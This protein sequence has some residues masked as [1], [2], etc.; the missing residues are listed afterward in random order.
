MVLVFGGFNFSDCYYLLLLASI[1][2]VVVCRQPPSSSSSSSLVLFLPLA[3]FLV[4]HL[5]RHHPTRERGHYSIRSNPTNPDSHASNDEESKRKNPKSKMNS[6]A[7]K[8][9]LK[10]ETTRD[11]P[12]G[13]PLAGVCCGSL[14]G[15]GIAVTQKSM[16]HAGKWDSCTSCCIGGC[17]FCFAL[18]GLRL[19]QGVACV[20]VSS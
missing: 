4:S 2:R 13:P 6:A 11:E 5:S 16:L 9:S 20:C 3:A 15:A 8:I 1:L 19:W 12:K 7:P 18:H 17:L 10:R 14:G